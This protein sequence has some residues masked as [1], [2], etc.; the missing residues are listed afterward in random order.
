MSERVLTITALLGG[1]LAPLPAAGPQD[2]AR[3]AIRTSGVQGGLVVHLGCGDGKLTA[4]LRAG[5]ALV[6]QGLERDPAAVDKARAH[7]RA[8]GLYGPVSIG[9]W[10]GGR[11]PYAESLVN[12]L[13]VDDA[14]RAGRDELLRVL[15]PGGVLL[16]RQDG[17]WRRTVKPRPADI[18]EFTH[19]LGDSGNNAV[20]RDTQAGQPRRLQWLADPLWLRTHEIPS[21]V[22]GL[23]AGGGRVFYIHD[24][25][26]V[27]I[28]D[29]RLPER[30]A[31]YCRD[32]FNGKLLWRRPVGPWGWT[33]WARARM[34][35]KDWTVLSGLRT[36]VPDENQRRL[37]ADGDRLYTTLGYLAPLSILDAATGEV[38]HTVKDTSPARQI[39]AADSLVIVY[40]QS[41][42]E[43]HEEAKPLDKKAK[44]KK[45]RPVRSDA[46]GGSL[47][48]VNAQTGQIL[49]HKDIP[50]LRGL[51][52]AL[53]QG[54]IVYQAGGSL[55]CLNARSGKELW[56][57]QPKV[58][59][60]RTM[61][62]AQGAV[63]LHGG[64]TL[65]ARGLDDGKALWDHDARPGVG[66]G[67]C[68]LFIIRGV[69]WP[70]V[71]MVDADRKPAKRAENGLAVGYD[72]RTG[73]P[74]KEVFVGE[75]FS[76]EHHHRCYRNK[77]TDR[78]M[79]TS[80]EGAEYLDVQGS[81][82][83]QNNFVRG[84]CRY[85]MLPANGLLYSPP[86]QCF[87]QPGAK[88][89]GFNA[90]APR[91]DK[92]PAETS[93]DQ[94]LQRGAAFADASAAKADDP[95]SPADWPTFR[96]DAARHGSTPAGVPAELSEAWRVKLGRGLT[97]PVA[98]NDRAYV[99]SADAHTVHALDLTTGRTVWSFVA[100]GRIDSP[101]T[102]HGALLLFGS[103]DGFVYCLRRS[104]GALAWRFQ[105]APAVR[106]IM[107]REQVESAWPVHGSVL[108]RDGVAYC[109]AGRSTYIDGG[110]RLWGLDIST[111]KIL[112]RGLLYGPQPD[113]KD[114]K[115]DLAFFI[116]GA[117]CDVLT[118]EGD[119]IYMR[120]KKLTPELKEI[121]VEP[122]SNKG[123]SDVGRHVFSTAGLL[124]SSWYNRTFWMYA[125][126][127]PGFQLANQAPKSGQ[128]L[129]V[130]DKATYAVKVFYRR[131]RHST[132]FFPAREGYLLFADRNENEPQ[133][134]GDKG[135]R[136]PIPWLPQTEFLSSKGV[137]KLDAADFGVDKGMGY[138][139]AEPPLWTTWVDFRVRAMVKAGDKLL[140]AGPPDVLDE[141]DAYAAFEGRKGAKLVAISAKDGKPLATRLLDSPPVF[142]GMIAA[143]G[144][145]L[146]SLE[147]GSLLC[148][149]GKD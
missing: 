20:A 129:V 70:G 130:D 25:G 131:N 111:G 108:V 9:R 97:A 69:V 45:A 56:Q 60:A 115:R 92:P 46:D 66:I 22:Q 14:A 85:G 24:E 82:H 144:R 58:R 12:L 114:V 36:I 149:A 86:D 145:V 83:G 140:A 3:E 91:A 101:P 35:D 139:R 41:R 74:M 119:A 37:V 79:I 44:G 136:K 21:G 133:I 93:H 137:R 125:S 122:V 31:L 81:D 16:E 63:V 67:T 142:D 52:L 143:R 127:W 72:L 147:D 4:A 43:Q 15:A 27:G 135:A 48:A 87:C 128:L 38:L 30:W 54:R 11:L 98:V 59:V 117:N 138:T 105:A 134:V 10:D 76:P 64:Q 18:G 113:G 80:Y 39:V 33:E 110:I 75:L 6:V 32:A 29:Q 112:H 68:D 57:V 106:L 17:K 126:R 84:A 8:L 55:C 88:L 109:T 148:L 49:W 65:E 116:R 23:V 61:V 19:F 78:F 104:D 71:Q 26:L 123:E 124:D 47:R 73:K 13:V 1:L 28:A 51:D 90:L 94:R 103:A 99:A 100:G 2:L 118:A 5:D 7:V 53:C 96:A 95:A 141:K 50:A 121:V 89:L 146:V 42:A 34:E 107:A 132:M 102:V 62:A 40:S 77:A 120:Q